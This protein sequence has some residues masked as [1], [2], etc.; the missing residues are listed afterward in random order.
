MKNLGRTIAIGLV[1]VSGGVLLGGGLVSSAR[2]PVTERAGGWVQQETPTPDATP[3]VTPTATPTATP[4]VTPTATPTATPTVTPTATP[5][6]TPTPEMTPTPTP[7][8][9]TTTTVADTT[10]TTTADGSTTTVADTTTTT[11][12][13]GSGAGVPTTTNPVDELPATGGS[14]PYWSLVWLGL[15]LAVPGVIITMIAGRRA[16]DTES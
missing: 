16:A 11:I 10:T 7:D 1:A 12:G 2:Q 8:E 14:M 3:T 4:T 15:A 9:S 6:P 5:T 13:D